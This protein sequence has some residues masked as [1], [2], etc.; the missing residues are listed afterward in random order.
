VRPRLPS[1]DETIIKVAFYAPYAPPFRAQSSGDRA[2]ARALTTG[3]EQN[4]H[5]VHLVSDFETH[6]FWRDWDRLRQLP[7]ALW[8]AYRSHT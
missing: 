6:L 5:R 1:P 7:K 8:D 3:L 4:G 2:I